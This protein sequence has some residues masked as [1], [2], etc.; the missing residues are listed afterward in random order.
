MTT[1]G[2]TGHQEIPTVA[3]A[4]VMERV[5]EALNSLRGPLQAAT[6]L[7]VG[8]DQ[9]VAGDIVSR[10]G[11]LHVILPCADYR[12]TFTS[13]V[14]LQQFESLLAA[15]ERVDTLDFSAPSEEAFWEAGKRVVDASDLLVAVWDGKPSRGLGGTAD[16]VNYAH[17][18]HKAVHV[19]WPTDVV[20]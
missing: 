12:R 7:A 6:S 16:V 2:I 5:E 4:E 10:G 13:R 1:V 19:I 8:A 17:D 11:R 20:R 9:L 18:Q 3:L 15:A 14:A